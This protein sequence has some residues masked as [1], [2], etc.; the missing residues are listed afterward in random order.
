MSHQ[1]QTDALI[2]KRFHIEKLFMIGAAVFAVSVAAPGAAN[3]HGDNIS[4][5][6]LNFGDDEA[7]LEQLIEL[8]ADDIDEIRVEMADAREDIADAIIEIEDAREEVREA[9]GGAVIMKIALGTA[10]KVVTRTTD[11]VFE[12]IT[13]DLDDAASELETVRVEIGDAEYNETKL[14]I[15]V[16]REELAQL[17][18]ALDEL[19]DAMRA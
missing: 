8:D 19:T 2:H 1:I 4:F 14:A 18:A 10:S 12:E 7:L 11:K 17:G 6:G 5:N 9:P 15:S 16:I 13:N 3:A